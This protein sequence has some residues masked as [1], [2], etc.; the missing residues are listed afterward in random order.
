[1][2]FDEYYLKEAIGK[3]EVKIYELYKIFKRKY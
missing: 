3:L 2:R 1:M